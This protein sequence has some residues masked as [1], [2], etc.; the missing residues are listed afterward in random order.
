MNEKNNHVYLDVNGEW[1]PCN[2]KMAGSGVVACRPQVGTCPGN[3]LDCFFKGGRYY[4]NINEPHIPNPDWVNENGLV[5]RMNDGNDSNYER[6]LVIKTASKYNDVFFNTRIPKLDFPG[7]VVLTVNGDYTD[8]A[9]WLVNPHQMEM[10]MA[11]RVRVNTWNT[12]LVTEV[13]NYYSQYNI[14]VR[15]TFMAYY[16]GTVKEPEHYIWKKRTVNPYWCISNSAR[17]DLEHRFQV[18]GFDIHTCTS[19]KGHYCRDCGKCLEVYKKWKEVH[20][21]FIRGESKQ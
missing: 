19:T 15:L 18:D 7:P 21:Y 9:A 12:A 5:V 1:R 14:P 2:P 8:D 17:K 3:C 10:L 6:D 11:V 4:E 16:F 13:I 20:S